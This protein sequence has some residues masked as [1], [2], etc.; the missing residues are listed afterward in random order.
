MF[1]QSPWQSDK[2]HK[3]AAVP[4]LRPTAPTWVH[5]VRPHPGLGAA[6]HSAVSRR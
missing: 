3:V 5:E 1:R 6:G 4:Y 2:R